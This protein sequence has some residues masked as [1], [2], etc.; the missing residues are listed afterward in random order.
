MIVVVSARTRTTNGTMRMNRSERR[1]GVLI[2]MIFYCSMFLC[3]VNDLSPKY[4]KSPKRM[5]QDCV[6]TVYLDD[7]SWSCELMYSMVV[8]CSVTDARISRILCTSSCA[9]FPASMNA[10]AV[11][12]T[13][14]IAPETTAVC[15]LID[16]EFELTSVVYDARSFIDSMI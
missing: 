4:V 6:A 14:E 16:A 2:C 3:C 5:T 11:S 12:F 15:R 13:V 8:A 10:F 1:N 9:F 7:S